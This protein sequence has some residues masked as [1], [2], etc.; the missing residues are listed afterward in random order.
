[1]SAE[2]VHTESSPLHAALANAVSDVIA[3]AIELGLE[4]DQAACVTVAVAADYA[5]GEY[6]PDYLT[7]LSKVVVARAA[8][9]LPE[10]ANAKPEAAHG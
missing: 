2:A 4:V 8:D 3:R 5:R 10:D 9:P 1:M 7:K 6:G